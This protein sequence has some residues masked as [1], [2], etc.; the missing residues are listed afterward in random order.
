MAINNKVEF[1]YF[2]KHS[3]FGKFFG[4]PMGKI[5]SGFTFLCINDFKFLK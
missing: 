2:V 4:K 1:S 3:F 5:L